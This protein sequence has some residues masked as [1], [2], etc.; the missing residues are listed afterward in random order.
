MVSV[1]S[2]GISLGLISL[3]RW[4]LIILLFAGSVLFDMNRAVLS[5]P[6]RMKDTFPEGEMIL[7]G[8]SCVHCTIVWPNKVATKSG[9]VAVSLSKLRAIHGGAIYYLANVDHQLISP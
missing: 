3:L 1:K 4:Y 7:E 8:G 9:S 5:L 6:C 2:P